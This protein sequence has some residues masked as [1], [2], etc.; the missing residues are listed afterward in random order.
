MPIQVHNPYSG[1]DVETCSVSFAAQQKLAETNVNGQ[2][3]EAEYH[4]SKLLGEWGVI[5]GKA[6][7]GQIPAKTKLIKV[8]GSTVTHVLMWNGESFGWRS[9]G[10][11]GVMYKETKG[12]TAQQIH[13]AFFGPNASPTFKFTVLGNEPET[14][15]EALAQNP[16]QAITL[17]GPDTKITMV[18]AFWSKLQAQKDKLPNGAV[19]AISQAGSHRVLWKDNAWYL[20]QADADGNWHATPGGVGDHLDDVPEAL[21]DFDIDHKMKTP[22]EAP[23]PEAKPA[24]AAPTLSSAVPAFSKSPGSMTDEDVAT[25]F[26]TVKDKLA[27]EKGLAIKGANPALD[28]EVYKAIGEQTGYT[29]AEAK[30]KV[31]AY[32]ATGKKLSALKKKTLKSEAKAPDPKPNHV[33]TVATAEVAEAVVEEVVAVAEDKPKAVYSNEDIAAQYV[34]A[35]DAIVA[36]SNGKW[37]LY[38]KSDELDLE[39]AIQVGLKTGLNPV[40]QKLAVAEYLATGKKLSQLKKGLIKQGKLKPEAETLKKSKDQQSAEAKLE[41]IASKAD[42]GFLGD[43]PEE[44]PSAPFEYRL[45]PD[46]LTFTGQTLGTHAAQVWKAA[47]GTKWLFKPQEAFLTEID[48]AAATLAKKVGHPTA[49]VFKMTL[50]GKQGSIQRMFDGGQAFPVEVTVSNAGD[51]LTSIKTMALQKEQV[52]DWLLSQHDSHYKNFVLDDH[53]NMVGI[54]KG[55]SFKYFGSDSLS[56]TYPNTSYQPPAY[57]AMWKAFKQGKPIPVNDPAAGELAAFIKQLQDLPAKDFKDI[58]RSYAEAAKA[59]GVLAP[60]TPYANDVDGFLD[61]LLERKNTLGQSFQKLYQEN[62]PVSAPEVGPEADSPGGIGHLSLVSKSNL[63]LAFKNQPNGKYL[64]DTPEATY[65]AILGT[66]LKLKTSNDP[67]LQHLTPLQILRVVDEQG[68]VKFSIANEKP[69]EKKVV[70]WL[71]TPEGK[72]KAQEAKASL[73]AAEEVAAAAKAPEDNQPPLP[74]DSVLFGVISTTKARQLQNEAEP[75]KTPERLGLEH[76]TGGNFRP[77]NRWLRGQNPTITEEDKRAI[78][79]ASAG[80]RPS[81]ENILLH[82]GTGF[83][84]FG[85][86][87]AETIWGLTGKLVQDKGFLSTSVGGRAAFSGQVMMEVECPKGTP[88]AYVDHISKHSGENEMLLQKGLYYR[89]LRI[90]KKTVGYSTTFVVRLRVEMKK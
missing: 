61:K 28:A 11:D 18:E 63:Y 43:K 47:D 38:T 39:I 54:D 90:E 20:Q 32:K 33:P 42:E 67:A 34:I 10:D 36:A 65:Q 80:M 84:Q 25:L 44:T 29:P 6:A 77:M 19:L 4:K 41:D 40:Q 72:A 12:K 1:E 30:G 7:S 37:T 75:W 74:A 79:R 50:N 48:V 78:E 53:G 46:D 16:I 15:K 88:M 71:T 51:H 62:K 70:E 8:Q 23:Q 24:H 5:K 14:K 89:V 45:K 86:V 85:H 60:G 9:Y 13:D 52:L 49:D 82:R 27:K 73:L 17:V 66:M 31:D 21:Y 81:T 87:D 35:K 58:F 2:Q 76:Y 69:F 56:P 3:T 59:K 68:A 83:E 26:V 22:P 64:T 55:Q 57:Q